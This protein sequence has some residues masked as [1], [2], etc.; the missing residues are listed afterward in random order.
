MYVLVGTGKSFFVRPCCDKYFV[1]LFFRETKLVG[2]VGLN[3]G[4]CNY[5]MDRGDPRWLEEAQRCLLGNDNREN[6][7]NK[8]VSSTRWECRPRLGYTVHPWFPGWENEWVVSGTQP[9]TN[10]VL[11]DFFS[12][13][14]CVFCWETR[15]TA[16]NHWSALQESSH[17]WFYLVN[18]L[19]LMNFCKGTDGW[20]CFLLDQGRVFFDVSSASRARKCLF[21]TND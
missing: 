3:W 16:I 9:I 7:W 11:F 4:D 12:A 20:N 8:E 5:E 19:L 13:C 15:R 21:F 14:V 10:V 6:D 17:L 2:A 1:L 18:F